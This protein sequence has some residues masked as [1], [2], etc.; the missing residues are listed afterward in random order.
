LLGWVSFDLSTINTAN[1]L[2][3]Y[4]RS[5][6]SS[7]G[8]KKTGTKVPA[9]KL[10]PESIPEVD[11]AAGDGFKYGKIRMKAFFIL[12][13]AGFVVNTFLHWLFCLV[14]FGHPSP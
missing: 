5:C 13:L 1:S 11:Q 2:N 4:T 6:F 3:G 14:V 7:I 9:N 8:A 12:I 10:K